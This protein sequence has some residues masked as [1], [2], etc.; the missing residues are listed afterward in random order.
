M[1]HTLSFEDVKLLREIAAQLD[2][3]SAGNPLSANQA[4]SFRDSLKRMATAQ[5]SEAQELE[6]NVA[7]A[8]LI[9]MELAG[10]GKSK[11]ARAIV[12]KECGVAEQTVST[13]TTRW[14]T[15][16]K[17]AIELQMSSLRYAGLSRT[18]VL[19]RVLDVYEK[20]LIPDLVKRTS[21]NE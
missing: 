12:A 3:H 7:G 10:P 5:V 19:E 18:Q 21:F 14:R 2:A 16:M 11:Q 8:Y 1:S 20:I 17:Q 13:Y 4:A 15:A 6:M 9:R